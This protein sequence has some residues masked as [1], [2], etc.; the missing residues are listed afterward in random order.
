MKKIFTLAAALCIVSSVSFAQN[1]TKNADGKKATKKT[2]VAPPASNAAGNG[3]KAT[4]ASAPTPAP[5]STPGQ[6]KGNKKSKAAN[7]GTKMEKK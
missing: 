2:E 4:P 5:A 7:E 1:A 3:K 6:N